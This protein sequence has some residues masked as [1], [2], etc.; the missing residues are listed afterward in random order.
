MSP[1]VSGMR[2]RTIIT[3]VFLV[4]QSCA[5]HPQSAATMP[6]PVSKIA[7]VTPAKKIPIPMQVVILVSEDSPAYSEV[8]KSLVKRLGQRGTIYYMSESQ[9]ENLKTVAKLKNGERTQFVSIGLSASLAAKILTSKQ[10]VF[11]QV[12]NYQDYAL[13]SPLHKGVSMLPSFAKTFS[14]WHALAPDTNDIAIITGPGFDNVIQSAKAAAKAH[15]ITLHHTAVNS[16][17]EYQYTY[18]KLST[19][20][21]AYW[22]LPD[23][24]V[25][26]ENILRDIMTFSVRNSKQVAVFSDELL[27]LGGLFSVRNDNNDIAFQVLERLEQAQTSNTIPGPDIVYPEK[28]S[29]RINPV[30]AHNLGLKIPEYYRKYANTL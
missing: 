4:L 30:M 23:N 8:A 12:Y 19:K 29:L 5:Q 25:L 15:G 9:A 3:L 1:K 22:L 18:K 21:Q 27:K 20:V 16:D 26:S 24:R 14:T 13:L 11:C 2:L 17:K 7:A 10:V 28:L 6:D